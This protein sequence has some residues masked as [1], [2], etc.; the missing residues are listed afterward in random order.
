[1]ASDIGRCQLRVFL[2]D[3]TVVIRPRLHPNEKEQGS[4][5]QTWK[6]RRWYDGTWYDI[7]VV[8]VLEYREKVVPVAL[9]VLSI[10]EDRML[11]FCITMNNTQ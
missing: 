3:K 8:R 1:M 7:R 6:K 4:L 11:E 10:G 9:R 2:G 5:G